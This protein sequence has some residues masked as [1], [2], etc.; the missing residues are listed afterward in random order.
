MGQHLRGALALAV[1]KNLIHPV[2]VALLGVVFGLSG[3]PLLV[4]VVTAALPIGANVFLFSQRYAVA[5]ELVTA[6]VI[7]SNALA[8]VTLPAVMLLGGWI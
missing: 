8:M 3:L 1:A 2:L 4:M 5:E 6:S 7:V